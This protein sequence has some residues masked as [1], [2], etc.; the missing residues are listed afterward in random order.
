LEAGFGKSYPIFPGGTLGNEPAQC[1]EFGHGQCQKKL[2][3]QSFNRCRNLR[4]NVPN[5]ARSLNRD[6]PVAPYSAKI[7]LGH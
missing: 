1:L 5:D 6:K 2:T 4:D 3:D 7:I